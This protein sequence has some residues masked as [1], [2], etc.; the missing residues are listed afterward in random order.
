[1]IAAVLVA[2]LIFGDVEAR[3]YAEHQVAHVIGTHEPGA[4]AK[5][6][7]K[8][9]PFVGRLAVSRQVQQVTA[10]VHNVPVATAA[11]NFKLDEVDLT[12]KGVKVDLGPLVAGSNDAVKSIRSGSVRAVM[13]E[14]ALAGLVK[15]PVTL[16]SGSAQVTVAGVKVN[17]SASVTNNVLHLVAG[18]T[19][20]M[21][22]LPAIPVLPC[23]PNVAIVPGDL[24]LSCTFNTVPAAFLKAAGAG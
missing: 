13:S 2:L 16:G 8:S 17:A 18:P 9:F 6:R 12:L 1:V 24:I 3:H 11:G 10:D 14:Q 22:K 5:V 4:T 20:V 23:A 21:V 15:L 19:T 7:I